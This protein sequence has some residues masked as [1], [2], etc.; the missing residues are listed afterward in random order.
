[1]ERISISSDGFLACGN[2][3]QGQ[4]VPCFFQPP[5]QSPFP[6]QPH[7]LQAPSAP[8]H[9]FLPSYLT[10]GVT[11]GWLSSVD[12]ARCSLCP[13]NRSGWASTRRFRF[14]RFQ[15][16]AA[17][18]CVCVLCVRTEGRGRHRREQGQPP[19]EP[20]QLLRTRSA[21]LR[22]LFPISSRRSHRGYRS[23]G[24]AQHP[25]DFFRATRFCRVAGKVTL[26]HPRPSSVQG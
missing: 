24:C 16:V 12:A 5:L 2:F 19:P 10:G 26:P 7:C 13:R 6:P 15:V 3:W 4:S 9:R 20:F 14:P 23:V 1:M 8:P 11:G 21:P 18:F 17:S 25:S 22:C